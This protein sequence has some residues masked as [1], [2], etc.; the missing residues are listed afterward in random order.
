MRLQTP[1]N[2]RAVLADAVRHLPHS[3]KV[4]MVAVELEDRDAT[5]RVVLRRALEHIPNSVRLWKVSLIVVVW[6]HCTVDISCEL[7][8]SQ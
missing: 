8:F 5:K 4:W 7:S 3:V 1:S 2:A 6:T